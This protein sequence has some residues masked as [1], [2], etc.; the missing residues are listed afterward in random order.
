MV[1]GALMMD[2]TVPWL[3]KLVLFFVAWQVMMIA[4]MLPTTLP[5]VQTLVSAVSGQSH[6]R[7][8]LLVF[9]AAYAVIWSGFAL[10]VFWGDMGVHRL[11][12][13]YSWTQTRPWLFSG[14]PLVFAGV[15]QFTSWKEICRNQ[16]QAPEAFISRHRQCSLWSV[17]HL[18]LEGGLYSLGCCWTLM[19][20]MFAAGFGSLLGMLGL[21][22]I[23][24]LEK[25]SQIGTRMAPIVGCLLITWGIFELSP[26]S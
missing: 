2:S 20:L 1:H 25:T 5:M 23:M 11:A 14:L 15:F 16:C 7:F 9:L 17:W 10:F 8:K 22:G 6:T 4:M 12:T 3:L 26:W 19:L 13:D 21:T 18:G 24:L